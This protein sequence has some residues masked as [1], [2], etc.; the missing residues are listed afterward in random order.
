M[1]V[2]RKLADFLLNVRYEDLPPET[3]D[4][5]KKIIVSILASAAVGSTIRSAQIVREI[6]AEQGGE[7]QAKAWYSNGLRLP[8]PNAVRI[9]AMLS[10]SAASDDSDIRNIAHIGTL[11]TSM[12]LAVSERTGATGKDVLA[13]IVAGYEVSGRIGDMLWPGLARRGFHGSVIIVFGGVIAGARLLGLT[14]GQTAEALS[15]AGTSIGGVSVNTHS[16]AREYHAGNAALAATNAV[17]AARKG[18]FA[19]P[20]TLESKGGFF[21]IFGAREDAAT[22]VLEGLGVEWDIC[23]HMAIKIW[24]GATPLAAAVEAAINATV[25]G[26]IKPDEVAAIRIAGPSFKT[27]YGHKH[28]KDLA[29]AVHSTAYYLAAGIVDRDFNW[30][31]VSMDKVLDPTIGALQD[32]VEPEPDKDPSRHRWEWGATVTLTLKDGRRYQSTVN[33][34]KG[35]GPRGIDWADV[36]RKV[37]TLVPQSGMSTADVERIVELGHGFDTLTSVAP[38]VELL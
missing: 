4:N 15:L 29:G 33:E 10:D 34:P 3:V 22:K 20:D 31:H 27:L 19:N 8:L 7:P 30:S 1:T 11:L 16:I 32:L 14:A 23:T 9:N 37:R 25:E 5:A 2:A 28:P 26:D 18:F 36:D 12:S 38:L 17:L 13:A 35:S 6:V 21:E 24:P